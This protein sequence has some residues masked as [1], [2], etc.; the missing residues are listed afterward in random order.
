MSAYECF[1]PFSLSPQVTSHLG[2]FDLQMHQS[3]FINTQYR[4]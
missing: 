2:I 1:G 4:L 3:I